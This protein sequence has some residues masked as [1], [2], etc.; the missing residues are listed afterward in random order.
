MTRFSGQNARRRLLHGFT[1][2]ELLVVIAIIGV[3]V[4]LLLPAVQAAR[5]AARRTQCSNNL[6]QIGLAIHNFHDAHGYLPPN[7]FNSRRLTWCV[8]VLPYLEQ[9]Q[10][11]QQFDTKLEYGQQPSTQARETHVRT[12]YCPSRRTPKLLSFVED[13]KGVAVPGNTRYAAGALGDY[14]ACVGTYNNAQWPFNFANGAIIDGRSSSTGSNTRL[15][16][17]TDGTSNTLMVGEKHV[18]RGGFGRGI[19]GDGSIYNGIE[20]VYS[21]RIAGREDPLALSPMDEGPSTNGDGNVP[22]ATKFG[23]WHTLVTGF[24]LCDASVHHLRNTLD[25]TTLERLSIRDDGLAVAL[26]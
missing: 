13:V 7:R 19:Y 15:A 24:V 18:P 22:T 10:L 11:F 20:S 9:N 25:T 16:V 1:L 12:Y 5:E 14:A 3:L 8:V 26:P 21:G 2:V 4:A 6:K 23:S 17:I